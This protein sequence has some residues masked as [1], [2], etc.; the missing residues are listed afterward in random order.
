MRK[1]PIGTRGML[2]VLTEEE[3]LNRTSA[4]PKAAELLIQAD[5]G[6]LKDGYV[7][8]L[9]KQKS[10]VSPVS[11]KDY[12]PYLKYSKPTTEEE[13][14]EYSE[15]KVLNFDTNPAGVKK[16]IQTAAELE[17]AERSVLL[18]K[19]SVTQFNIKDDDEPEMALFKQALNE[20]HIDMSSY[21]HR[22]G[23]DYS[24]NFRLLTNSN[25]ITFNKMKVLADVFDIEME[26][27]FRDKKGCLNPMGKEFREIIN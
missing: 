23:S 5:T 2:D 1:M 24:N 14:K 9:V 22:Q 16:I 7:Y 20:K 21:R 17:A 15:A 12:G 6:I 13:K 4:N 18:T 3:Y 26:I 10:H 27:I 11:V 19:D 8:P 25:S